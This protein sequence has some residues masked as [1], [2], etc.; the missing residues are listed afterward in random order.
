MA[1]ASLTRT[2]CV[3][4]PAPL[5]N[6]LESGPRLLPTI[7]PAVLVPLALKA[8]YSMFEASLAVASEP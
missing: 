2:M 7:S 1:G 5:R 4:V 8:P 6:L 3:Y